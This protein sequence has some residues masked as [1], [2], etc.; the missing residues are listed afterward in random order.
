MNPEYTITSND[1]VRY[2][3]GNIVKDIINNT[4]TY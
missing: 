4:S 2:C 1:K 3:M